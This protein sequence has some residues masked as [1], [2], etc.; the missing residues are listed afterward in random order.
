MGDGFNA[1]EI[2]TLTS[3]V[4]VTLAIIRNKHLIPFFGLIALAGWLVIF[5][6]IIQ[7]LRSSVTK[8]K[9]NA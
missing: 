3:C 9:D 6:E 4:L 7:R 5:A 1:V 2:A 8:A